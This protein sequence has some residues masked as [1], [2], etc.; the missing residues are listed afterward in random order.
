MGEY[1]LIP[2]TVVQAAVAELRRIADF[3]GGCDH[4]VGI[5]WCD[6]Y[7]LADQLAA[8]PSPSWIPVSERLRQHLPAGSEESRCVRRGDA[9]DTAAQADRGRAAAWDEVRASIGCAQESDHDRDISAGSGGEGCEFGGL[10][11]S[12]KQHLSAAEIR[13]PVEYLVIQPSVQ[14]YSDGENKVSGYIPRQV[15]EEELGIALS[16]NERGELCHW[17]TAEQAASI[18]EHPLFVSPWMMDKDDAATETS[19]AMS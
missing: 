6:V 18:K 15:V 1:K 5:C 16:R 7:N 11:M 12:A 17:F 4:S 10:I 9:R 8:A 19:D 13:T 14:R 2:S 3:G